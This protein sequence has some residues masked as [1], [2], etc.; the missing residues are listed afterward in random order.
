MR[1]VLTPC[2]PQLTG[3]PDNGPS[4]N[5]LPQISEQPPQDLGFSGKLAAKFV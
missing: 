3:N 1:G 2:S 4:S 5:L